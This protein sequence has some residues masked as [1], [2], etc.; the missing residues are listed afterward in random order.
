MDDEDLRPGFGVVDSRL[1]HEPTSM[2]FFIEKVRFTEVC[3]EVLDCIQESQMS[4]H[5]SSH[6]LAT[7]MSDRYQAFMDDMPWFPKRPGEDTGPRMRGLLVQRPYIF[8]QKYVLL[9][10]VYSRMGR[11]HR[12]FIARSLREPRF[13]SSRTVAIS[14][15]RQQVK[16]CRAVEPGDLYPYIRS[17]SIDQHVFGGL[18][19]LAV[20]IMAGKDEGGARGQLKELMDTTTMIK[21]KQQA[22]NPSNMTV[23]VA[24]DKL[25]DVLQTIGQGQPPR[26]PGDGDWGREADKPRTKTEGP[27]AMSLSYD[28]MAICAFDSDDI[29]LPSFVKQE[30][31]ELWTELFNSSAG[32]N[33]FGIEER[34]LS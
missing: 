9:H 32:E 25:M 33:S 8:R 16:F 4:I 29:A 34:M 6:A 21:A 27:V 13:A 11:L 17:H 7:Q 26:P 20:D 10:A 19:L 3:R 12:P 14:C 31:E 5:P 23:V 28:N 30:M 2:S 18:V 24:I 22:F 15:A 1:R